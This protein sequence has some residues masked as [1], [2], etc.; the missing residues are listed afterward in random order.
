MQMLLLAFL[1]LRVRGCHS[2]LQD[3]SLSQ[4]GYCPLWFTTKLY[5]GVNAQVQEPR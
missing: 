4:D 3:L 1:I 5:I 2:Q